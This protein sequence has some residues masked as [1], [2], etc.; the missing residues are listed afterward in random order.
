[1]TQNMFFQNT[2]FKIGSEKHFIVRASII[3]CSLTWI[4]CRSGSLQWILAE[5]LTQ[6]CLGDHFLYDTTMS[7]IGQQM[8]ENG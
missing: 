1:M 4:S 5:I 2:I 6:S 3:N 8:S 7:K